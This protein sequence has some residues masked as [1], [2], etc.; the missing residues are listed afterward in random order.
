M[1]QFS[2][3]ICSLF[4]ITVFSF[5]LF[6][7]KIDGTYPAFEKFYDACYHNLNRTGDEYTVLFQDSLQEA[8]A[9]SDEFERTIR[10]AWTNYIMGYTFSSLGDLESVKKYAD[11]AETYAKQAVDTSETEDSLLI[12]ANTIG[13]NCV[14]KPLSYLMKNGANI[15]PLAK[16]ALKLN[17]KNGRAVFLRESQYIYGP[18]IIANAKRG[19]QSMLDILADTT[20][21]TSDQL[22]FDVNC[23]AAFA[24]IKLNRIEEAKT[25][26][27]AAGQL[28]PDN[29]SYIKTMEYFN[30]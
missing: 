20:L 13:L 9:V 5:P 3:S 29:I 8:Q 22:I 4:L 21:E 27:T 19:L 7:Q 11:I 6:A 16:K 18:A 15:N 28:F 17:P 12:Y 24:L 2:K 14:V 10:L 26:L 30:K 25:Y 23:A 1:K